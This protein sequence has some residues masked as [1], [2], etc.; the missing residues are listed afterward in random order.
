MA[1]GV[2]TYV[3]PVTGLVAPTATQMALLS[4]VVADVVFG[5][6]DT[7][8]SISHNMNTN[9]TGANG[10]P[11][12]SFAVLAGGVL[13]PLPVFAYVDANTVSI[14]KAAVGAT[15]DATYRVTLHK[16]TINR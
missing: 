4:S 15:T 12:I 13:A 9:A 16:S 10:L 3:Y 6:N 1:A 8:V 5:I 7:I 11:E 14:A 2:V